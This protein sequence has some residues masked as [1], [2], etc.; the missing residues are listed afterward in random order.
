MSRLIKKREQE[1]KKAKAY[2]TQLKTY[3]MI[4][5]HSPDE[6]AALARAAQARRHSV[7]KLRAIN[8]QLDLIKG[9]T[10]AHELTL[11]TDPIPPASYE[12][13][14]LD[15]EIH[16]LEEKKKKI[17][18]EIEKRKTTFKQRTQSFTSIAD[19]LKKGE[20]IVRMAIE[21]A[22]QPLSETFNPYQK[23][24]LQGLQFI[25][26]EKKRRTIQSSVAIELSR[27]P[28]DSAA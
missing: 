8:A 23:I 26:Q 16:A 21:K 6:L 2:A 28:I 9:E 25:E 10:R 27:Q 11:T 22:D 1:G 3:S 14:K 19:I 15:Q 17:E 5:N 24:S 7:Q 20:G 18:A 12:L 13:Q 4:E